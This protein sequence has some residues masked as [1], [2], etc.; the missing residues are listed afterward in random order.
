MI[1]E[2]FD[3]P[4]MYMRT[5]S[6][7]RLST[8]SKEHHLGIS[9]KCA[10]V[11]LSIIQTIKLIESSSRTR[12]QDLLV[13]FHA[14]YLLS[15]RVGRR[16][17]FLFCLSCLVGLRWAVGGFD[18]VILRVAPRHRLRCALTS[19]PPSHRGSWT[20][21]PAAFAFKGEKCLIGT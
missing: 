14:C 12:T 5:S 9:S 18:R 2:A 8:I 11:V 10:K 3:L 7:L 13:V 16:G 1:S 6:R 20:H 19:R 17:L 15:C 4:P 21:A